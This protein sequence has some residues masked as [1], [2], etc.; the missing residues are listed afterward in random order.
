M[1]RPVPTHVRFPRAP[2]RRRLVSDH[3]GTAAQAAD[4][5]SAVQDNAPTAAA[6]R[7]CARGAERVL[8]VGDGC[9]V[10]VRYAVAV[11]AVTA[12][13]ADAL[14]RTRYLFVRY[15][16]TH[17]RDAVVAHCWAQLS[18]AFARF[19]NR[20][21]PALRDV[22]MELYPPVAAQAVLLGLYYAFPGS[23]PLL[24][25][26][27]KQKVHLEVC[28]TAA[29]CLRATSARCLLPL[30]PPRIADG[31]PDDRHRA[32]ATLL[33]HHA[34]RTVLRAR[35]CPSVRA[36]PP[37][38]PLPLIAQPLERAGGRSH[39]AAAG[40]LRTT[41]PRAQHAAADAASAAGAGSAAE[42]IPPA[43]ARTE[44]DVAS[45][46]DELPP[47]SPYF[48]PIKEL[49]GFKGDFDSQPS[50]GGQR[51]NRRNR[52]RSST[53]F[54]LA[55]TSPLL[56]PLVQGARATGGLAPTLAAT[57]RVR[58]RRTT[59]QS[60]VP[61]PTPLVAVAQAAQAAE[62]AAEADSVRTCARSFA[63]WRS[64]RVCVQGAH[65]SDNP[66]AS[67]SSLVQGMENAWRER[68]RE[69]RA[70]QRRGNA[71]KDAVCD[72]LQ[73]ES[74]HPHCSLCARVALTP[75]R[76]RRSARHAPRPACVPD[77]H[78]AAKVAAPQPGCTHGR[79]R[80]C[81]CTQ[82]GGAGSRTAALRCPPLAAAAPSV[83]IGRAGGCP[84]R[85]LHRHHHRLGAGARAARRHG[86]DR[87]ECTPP[88]CPSL[89]ACPHPRGSRAARSRGCRRGGG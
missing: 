54:S 4:G 57:M 73:W 44:Q 34:C 30:S 35:M 48:L 33:G 9:A 62:P 66:T 53:D 19:F 75:P 21:E 52:Q 88:V 18:A 61:P 24:D 51:V 63:P 10:L 32:A 37:R 40:G 1:P 22:V 68:A 23:R 74:E 69:M 36:A 89:S 50:P 11:A 2:D 38:T 25:N 83:C 77:R 8:F 29:R 87:S 20:L 58:L 6:A 13:C 39:G 15:F 86:C 65:E 79:A 43:A 71:A 84:L 28:A 72:L 31:T 55:A 78:E 14:H 27:F 42:G 67:L 7:F 82:E 70:G 60:E 12:G 85:P 5:A 16:Q 59:Q 64:H 80:R 76:A 45:V 46:L 17:N 49:F 56:A 41:A 3:N 81:R 26:A 47:D